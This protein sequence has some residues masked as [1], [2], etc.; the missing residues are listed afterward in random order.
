MNVRQ[1]AKTAGVVVLIVG[2][3]VVLGSVLVR[4]QIAR[5]RRDLF[6]AHPL[7]RL[8]ALTYLAGHDATIEVVQLLRDFVAWEPRPLIRRRGAKV[9]RQMEQA[10]LREAALRPEEVPG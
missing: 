9:L 10:M 8:A 6:S 3:V 2:A 1:I 7:R 5:S 4:D